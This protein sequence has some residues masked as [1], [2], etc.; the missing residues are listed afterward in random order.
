MAAD[1]DN[2]GTV[3][4]LN[5]GRDV[6]LP[7]EDLAIEKFDIAPVPPSNQQ[8]VRQP[9]NLA[10]AKTGTRAKLAVPKHPACGHRM[11]Y[12]VCGQPPVILTLIPCYYHSLGDPRMLPYRR[13]DLARLDPE[14]PD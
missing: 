7:L 3:R 8:P 5:A 6:R 11:G 14:S 13:L 9:V 12:Y 1:I 2:G 10:D 4:Q